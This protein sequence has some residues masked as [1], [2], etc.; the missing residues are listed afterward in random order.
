MAA[1]RE[2][3]R[4]ANVATRN[5]P[6]VVRPV[7]RRAACRAACLQIKERICCHAIADAPPGAIDPSTE[8]WTNVSAA[9]MYW[10]TPGLDPC[11]FSFDYWCAQ[12]PERPGGAVRSTAACA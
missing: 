5:R 4:A 3:P 9:D 12:P 10:A 2:R 6:P 7:I 1:T 11:R 8:I